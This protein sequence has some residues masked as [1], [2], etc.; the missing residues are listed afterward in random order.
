MHL[1]KNTYIKAHLD[2]EDMG[3]SLISWFTREDPK[4][5]YFSVFQ[6]CLKFNTKKGVAIF[7]H[8]KKYVHGTMKFQEKT[9][10]DQ[11]YKVGITMVNKKQLRTRTINQLKKGK[12]MT[13]KDS[14]SGGASTSKQ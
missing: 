3:A 4:G 8:S 10:S 9:L 5:G 1:S 14:K 2:K 13:W 12:S 6:S 11:V 7:I